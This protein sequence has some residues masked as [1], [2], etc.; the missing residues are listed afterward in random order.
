MVDLHFVGDLFVR[1][2]GQVLDSG[3]VERELSSFRQLDNGRSSEHLVA[4]TQIESRVDPVRN[5]QL[6]VR[7]AVGVLEDWLTVFGDK[8]G[9]GEL[10]PFHTFLN[11][12]L[13]RGDKLRFAQLLQRRSIGGRRSA[14]VVYR[15]DLIRI[16]RFGLDPQVTPLAAVSTLHQDSNLVVRRFFDAVD[17][18]A[19][20]SIVYLLKKVNL[21][22]HG[23]L[24]Q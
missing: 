11:E 22:R 13:E 18:E 23:V 24:F 17:L 9:A 8:N 4:G 20:I 12:G 16:S 1:V 2:F 5:V 3:I 6:L 7:Q 15:S 21:A 14:T 19:I 10:I